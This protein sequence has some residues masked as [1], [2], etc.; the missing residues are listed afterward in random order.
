MH[1]QQDRAPVSAEASNITRTRQC[2]MALTTPSS[3]DGGWNRPW[4]LGFVWARG[5]MDDGY[6]ILF[7]RL[8]VEWMPH[9]SNPQGLQRQEAAEAR[10][11]C[12]SCRR[13]GR[14]VLCGFG[15]LNAQ[16]GKSIVRW[17]MLLHLIHFNLKAQLRSAPVPAHSDGKGSWEKGVI[18]V[19]VPQI[20][21]NARRDAN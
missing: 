10:G 15:N 16:A 7:C 21:I 8:Q 17:L 6:C 3:G 1:A 20:P 14:C 4:S 12:G 18:L 9:Q 2:S 5:I 13:H 11:D 19:A